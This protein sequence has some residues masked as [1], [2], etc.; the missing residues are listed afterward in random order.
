M[1]IPSILVTQYFQ[2]V[3]KRQFAEAERILERIKLKAEKTERNRGYLQALYGILLSNK[4]NNDQYTF[5]SNISLN[6][7]T[8]LEKH[9]REFLK[10]T[11]NSLHAEY[12]RGF[13]SAW[14]DFTRVLLKLENIPEP[15]LVHTETQY[16]VPEETTESKPSPKMEEVKPLKFVQT[17]LEKSLNSD[18]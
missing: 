5:L 14:A 10:H 18:N 1:P 2:L 15:Q 12:D 4:S 8:A 6:D 7:K 3:A 9:R 17:S 11:H 13:F 16:T